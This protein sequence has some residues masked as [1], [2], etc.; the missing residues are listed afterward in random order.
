MN[1]LRVWSDA[2]HLDNFLYTI[3]VHLSHINWWFFYF[4]QD[5]LGGTCAEFLQMHQWNW[6]PGLQTVMVLVQAQLRRMAFWT[7]ARGWH[8]CPSTPVLSQWGRHRSW[9]RGAGKASLTIM[10][11][12]MGFLLTGP[13]PGRLLAEDIGLIAVLA[14]SKY[15]FGVVIVC[16]CVSSSVL[17]HLCLFLCWGNRICL[18]TDMSCFCNK[19]VLFALDLAQGPDWLCLNLLYLKLLNV[20]FI[21][22]FI[23]GSMILFGERRGL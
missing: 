5:T 12:Q 19:T 23:S 21:F 11:V 13:I 16:V 17:F 4:C 9:R 18:V 7:Q 15:G 10:G 3:P 20:G 8:N 14:G 2:G 1:F 22:F 6:T